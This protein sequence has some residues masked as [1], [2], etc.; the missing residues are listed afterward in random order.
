MVSWHHNL[1]GCLVQQKLNLQLC[2]VALDIQRDYVQIR[3]WS[4]KFSLIPQYLLQ[5][6]LK[7]SI[8]N[9][10][11]GNPVTHTLN[12]SNVPCHT[13]L[14]H[15]LLYKKPQLRFQ[16]LNIADTRSYVVTVVKSF[17]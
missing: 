4:H 14:T 12:N 5:T 3:I 9:W 10:S 2:T 15:D 6:Q 17:T 13:I 8:W 11:L 1:L 7:F 16:Y